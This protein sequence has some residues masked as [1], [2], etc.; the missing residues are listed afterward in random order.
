MSNKAQEAAAMIDM[1]PE[2]EKDFALELLKRIVLAWDPDCTKLT[3]HEVQAL[4]EAENSGFISSEDIDW[5]NL[6]RYL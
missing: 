5:D 1:L 2:Q 6:E 3:P 4:V